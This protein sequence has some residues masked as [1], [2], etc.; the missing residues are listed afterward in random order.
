MLLLLLLLLA[1][2]AA[3]AEEEGAVMGGGSVDG[4]I[5]SAR[6]YVGVPV[7]LFLWGVRVL[8]GLLCGVGRS[9]VWVCGGMGSL[10][11]CLGTGCPDSD[12][13]EEGLMPSIADDERKRRPIYD[14]RA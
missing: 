6:G 7:C 10:S 5:R 3:A 2:A 9:R 14:L 4:L 13:S 11:A 12:E 1:A 8:D